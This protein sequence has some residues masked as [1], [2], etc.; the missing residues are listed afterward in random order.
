MAFFLSSA[1]V[2][3]HGNS[4]QTMIC[5][6]KKPFQN[7]LFALNKELSWAPG[8]IF[9]VTRIHF[10]L[11]PSNLDG[12]TSTIFPGCCISCVQLTVSLKQITWLRTYKT[13]TTW[14][15]MD[16][17]RILWKMCLFQETGLSWGTENGVHPT[18][19]GQMGSEA[20]EINQNEDR[21]ESQRDGLC[22]HWN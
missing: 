15:F 1:A 13:E 20:T 11:N 5:G 9:Q 7:S 21:G 10:W 16:C 6:L 12:Q 17:T 2:E 19:N 18:V 14:Y 8:V 3:M 22:I 4:Q